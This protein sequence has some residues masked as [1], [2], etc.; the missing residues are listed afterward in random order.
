METKTLGNTGLQVT[1]LGFGLAEIERQER[2]GGDVSDAARVLE[3]AL[4]GGINFLDTAACYAGT[5]ELIGRTVAHRRDEYVLA[6]KCGHVVGD[7]T[8]EAWS[9]EV[10]EHSI[11]RSLRRMKTDRVDILQL[12]SPK[13]DVLQNGEAV[14][15]IVRARE[16]GK[17]RFLGF[18]GDNE[19]AQ[20]AIESGIFDTLQTSFNLV[21]QYARNGLLADARDRG[22][23]VIV[24][25]PVAKGAW[26]KP[27][28]PSYYPDGAY[29]ISEDYLKRAQE[30][31]RLGPIPGAPEN[32]A[33]LAIGFVFAHPEVDTVLVGSNNASHV[34]S[35]VDWVENRLPIA[36]EAVDELHRRFDQLGQDW[37]QLV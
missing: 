14:D 35:N 10:I 18:S 7:T 23:G 17:T 20:W 21:D 4:D 19:P 2:H 9:A 24:K 33:L 36:A 15:A 11:D 13:L 31:E 29:A 30:M 32:P 22:M 1:R 3:T 37:E 12:H 25:R 16:A 6:T 26:G 8:A 34:T 5:E 28:N 27:S